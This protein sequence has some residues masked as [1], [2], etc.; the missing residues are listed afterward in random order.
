[1][2]S[3]LSSAGAAVLH[4]EAVVER[5]ASMCQETRSKAEHILDKAM[6]L[7]TRA[8][9]KLNTLRKSDFDEFKSMKNPPYGVVCLMRH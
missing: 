8:H 4:A 1:M 7:L 9:K 3:S 2:V 6:P 5:H